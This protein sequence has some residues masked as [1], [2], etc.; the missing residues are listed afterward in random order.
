[1]K[2]PLRPYTLTLSILCLGAA[3]AATGLWA[4]AQTSQ[5]GHALHRLDPFLSHNNTPGYLGVLVTDVDNET[6]TKLKLKETR[7]ALITL[8]DHDAPA[9]SAL[10]VN[11]VVQEINGQR[12]EGA[13]Q[14]GRILKEVPA[15][16]DVAIVISRDGA[17]VSVSV[18][19]VDR[20]ELQ[21]A[22][23]EIG[24]HNEGGGS[25][26]PAK[27]ILP[28]G[29][30]TL[31]HFH[32][33]IFGST[34]KVGAMVEPLAAQ[35]ADY[36]G[37]PSG[38]MIKQI[39]RK[40]EA[41]AAGLKAYDVVLKVGTEPIATTADWDRAI[42][43]N[44][45]KSVAITILR[46]RRQQTV[47][48]QV[49]SKHKSEVEY[50]GLLPDGPSPLLALMDSTLGPA[51]QEL[52]LEAQVLDPAQGDGR[53]LLDEKAMKELQREMEQFGK[54][55]KAENFGIDAQ[56]MD[57]LKREMEQFRGNFQADFGIDARQ[58][59]EL[60]KQLEEFGRNFKAQD[61][62]IDRKQMDE[63]RRQMEE[64]RKAMPPM[65][66]QPQPEVQPMAFVVGV[67]G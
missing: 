10:R 33:S 31:P 30:A 2:Y 57:E 38:V 56:Q 12:I 37:V 50:P 21:K 66:N 59:A 7:G 18:Q 28:S 58:M 34:L 46:E 65:W 52:V 6:A 53:C 3:V 54:Q 9:G 20:K 4:Q 61:F 26:S 13:E 1:M 14:F 8:I 63:L 47:T 23:K 51:G 64:F 42:R 15:G 11:D 41:D 49:D 35:M 29:D 39:A 48:L 45:G 5:L 22:W 44:E 40:S 36:L 62:G 17:P 55:F 32:A 19:L 43:A 67:R 25:S 24:N 27:A 16:H 60:R